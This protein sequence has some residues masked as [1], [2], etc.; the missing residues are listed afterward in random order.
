MNL[1]D[2][3]Q[4]LRNR[5]KKAGTQTAAADELGVSKS[6]LSDVLNGE[7]EPGEKLLGALGLERREVVTYVRKRA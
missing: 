7:R 4:M 2:V 5:I 3:I 6:F 1:K